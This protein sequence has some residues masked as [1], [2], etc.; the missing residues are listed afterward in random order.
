MKNSPQE[1]VE[2]LMRK[3]MEF[4]HLNYTLI[5]CCIIDVKNTIDA[6]KKLGFKKESVVTIFYNE[7]LKILKSKL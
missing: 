2:M 7:V 5:N 6:L 1:Y 3:H 4:H